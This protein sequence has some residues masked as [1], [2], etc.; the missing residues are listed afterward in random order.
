MVSPGATPLVVQ[1]S[2]ERHGG[3]HMQSILESLG[4]V[5]NQNALE[6]EAQACPYHSIFSWSR[7]LTT[8]PAPS[9][10]S[11]SAPVML[12]WAVPAHP[13]YLTAT[14]AFLGSISR[15][16]CQ[17]VV[18]TT[19]LGITAQ[20]ARR[21]DEPGPGPNAASALQSGFTGAKLNPAACLCTT[22]QG[23][24]TSDKAGKA[25]PKR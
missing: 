15:D 8:S 14:T 12:T 23:L 1:E 17:A 16:R 4:D 3:Y 9:T 6:V 22:K 25:T 5:A 21:K 11:P 18:P 13:C 2:G 24:K 7:H 20:P 10:T 19:C